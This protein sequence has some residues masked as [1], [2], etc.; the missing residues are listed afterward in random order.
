MA[1]PIGVG[2]I[3]AATLALSVLSLAV[4]AGAQE[5]DTDR[6][7]D[8]IEKQLRETRSIVF[9][10]RDTGQPVVVKPDGPDPAVTALQARVDDMDQTVRRLSGQVE[11]NGHDLDETRTTAQQAHDAV[12]E[13]RAQLQALTDR[14]S[15]LEAQLN[16]QPQA[17]AAP[18]YQPPVVEDRRMRAAP[19]SA[20]DAA[21]R[22]Q[23]EDQGVLAN[24][25][26]ANTEGAS[27]RNALALQEQGDYAGASQAW[28]DFI[29]HYGAGAK[30]KEARYRLGETLYIQS[31]YGEAARAYAEALKGWP[32]VAWAPDATVKLSQSLA[33]LGRRDEACSVVG[34]FET[35]YGPTAPPAVRSRARAVR[36]KAACAVG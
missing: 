23:A 18:P 16:S 22:A 31:D 36:A 25:P 13:L 4:P 1:R 2:M 27:Y 3:A 32:K 30:G 11:V 21:A 8:R 26:A 28:Q 17:A 12:I 24:P 35:R 14:V 7:L 10:G 9:Q 5:T 34:E 20:P 6:R 33:Q 19:R 29:A 15:K